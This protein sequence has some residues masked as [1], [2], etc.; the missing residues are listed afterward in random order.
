MIT[1][2]PTSNQYFSDNGSRY[3]YVYVGYV[4]QINDDS[5]DTVKHA[6]LDWKTC[7]LSLKYTTATFDAVNEIIV[8]TVDAGTDYLTFATDM[9]ALGVAAGDR[10]VIGT[11][12][13]TAFS[14]LLN[15]YP[16][17]PEGIV[18]DAKSADIG[19][20]DLA[21]G[22]SGYDLLSS[23]AANLMYHYW[24]DYT[25]LTPILKVTDEFESGGR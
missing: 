24:C 4:F 21:Y 3:E 7:T 22:A 25:N 18:I 17:L 1:L 13:D 2:D 23:Y 11:P 15:A 10:L 19:V 5:L 8:D 9:E 16:V 12:Y 20:G 6:R 14:D